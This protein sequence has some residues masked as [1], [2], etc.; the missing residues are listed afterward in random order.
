[1]NKPKFNSN[2]HQ[3]LKRLTQPILIT[4]FATQTLL[5]GCASMDRKDESVE[6]IL[7][8]E[9]ALIEKLKV[10]RQSTEVQQGVS[11]SESLKK[12]ELH[13]DLAL[14]EMLK[15]NEVMTSKILKQNTQ[16]VMLE[17]GQ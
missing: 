14:D 2:T 3:L 15:A 7:G 5:T 6:T 9:S 17:R 10:E 8:R 4:A 1:M 12:A 13:L 11:Q 16:E